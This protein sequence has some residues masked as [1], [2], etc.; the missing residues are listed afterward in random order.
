[1]AREQGPQ[2]EL[3]RIRKPEFYPLVGDPLENLK[4]IGNVFGERG[5]RIAQDIIDGVRTGEIT[6]A[7][8]ELRVKGED[9]P[10]LYI[11]LHRSGEGHDV[12]VSLSGDWKTREEIPQGYPLIANF[13]GKFFRKMSSTAE[14]EIAQEEDIILPDGPIGVA[15]AG[16]TNRWLY[17]LPPREFPKGARLLR[18]TQQDGEPVVKG[19]T[20]ICYVERST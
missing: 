14:K 20:I 19:E 17:R 1:M 9:A 4:A 15:M 7:S 6:D 5:A 3:D 2:G 18:F 10:R 13:D 12:F 11:A 16:K 8:L